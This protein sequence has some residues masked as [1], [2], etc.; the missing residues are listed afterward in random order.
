[1]GLTVACARCHDHKY[2]PIPTRDYYS[3]Y[4]VFASSTEP[5]NLPLLGEPEETP[6]YL[7]FKKELDA[8]QK[9]VAD[10][11]E[12]NKAELAAKNRKFRDELKALEK[13]VDAWQAGSPG[14]PPRAM[15][16]EDLPQPREPHVLLRG[17][18]A[19][20]GP[21][22]PRQFLQVLAGDSR[23]PFKTGSGRLE[24]AR[25]IASPD[26]PLTA[27]VLV[28]RVWIGHFGQGLVRTPS[29]FGVRSDPPS[30]PELLDWLARR[31]VQ[32]GWSVKR[33]HKTIMLSATYQQASTGPAELYGLDPDNRLLARQNRRRLDFE[34]MRDS[35]L[36]AAGRLDPALGGRSV[37]LFKAPFST[38]RTVYGFIDRQNLPGTMRAFDMA[39]P[40][41][42]SP[43]RFQTT[44]PTQSL[45]LM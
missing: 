29:D 37:D 3:L 7:A 34:S 17:N 18:P 22:V 14:A 43:Q 30:H 11:Q 45:F 42:H 12:K 25:A 32:D 33:L 8:R 41:Q 20:V 27:R 23:Q 10:Y 21:K 13:K 36:S 39:S 1:L 44:V 35:V 15:V 38:R 24:L 5:K 16:L 19:N 2:D 9:A 6:E 4:G 31:F 40:D 28:N 26:N